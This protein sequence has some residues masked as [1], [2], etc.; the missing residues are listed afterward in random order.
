GQ[1]AARALPRRARRPRVGHE[2]AE[3]VGDVLGA[4]HALVVVFELYRE[5]SGADQLAVGRNRKRSSFRFFVAVPARLSLLDAPGGELRR[6]LILRDVLDERGLGGD[7]S[8]AVSERVPEPPHL[9][10]ETGGE[11]EKDGG[12]DLRGAHAGWDTG[13]NRRFPGSG[14]SGFRG[15][16]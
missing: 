13:T 4:P 7:G 8:G 1:R 9:N 2:A 6:P 12:R 11:Q 5:L 3:C 16:R 14:P 10:P 15:R